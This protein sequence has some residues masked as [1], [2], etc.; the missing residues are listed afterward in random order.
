MNYLKNSNIE[1]R[2]KIMKLVP[3]SEYIT[4]DSLIIQ[5]LIDNKSAKAKTFMLNLRYL[6]SS[7]MVI[8]SGNAVRKTVSPEVEKSLL[9]F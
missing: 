1:M 9:P 8:I 4:I 5:M 3:T 7:G 6:I 2:G